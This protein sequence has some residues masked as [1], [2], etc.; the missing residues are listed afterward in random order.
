MRLAQARGSLAIE[1][2]EERDKIDPN[3]TEKNIYN[4][5]FRF[6]IHVTIRINVYI[7]K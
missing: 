7:G 4:L 6:T 2:K 1:Q 5:I 3:R